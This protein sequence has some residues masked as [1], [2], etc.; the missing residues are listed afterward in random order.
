MRIVNKNMASVRDGDLKKGGP[1]ALSSCTPP[2][3]HPV[4]RNN[5]RNLSTNLR[6]MP[7][8]CF[9]HWVSHLA[10]GMGGTA[11]MG[12]GTLGD[13][14]KAFFWVK[15]LT[16]CALSRWGVWDITIT[17]FRSFL[18]LRLSG[19]RGRAPCSGTRTIASSQV[20]RPAKDH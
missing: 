5:T 20:C 9:R 2:V 19:F 4:T 14:K 8:F 6:W 7:D 1:S 18:G 10:L 17:L 3:A 12:R 11:P 15:S 13:Q 16:V